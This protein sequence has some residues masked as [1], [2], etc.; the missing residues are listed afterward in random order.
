MQA[1]SQ[2]GAAII[3]AVISRLGYK[4]NV[5]KKPEPLV[6]PAIADR[7]G[8][9]KL[10]RFSLSRPTELQAIGELIWFG[11]EKHARGEM[12]LWEDLPRL[13]NDRGAECIV[14]V[15]TIHFLAL[16]I[17]HEELRKR[18]AIVLDVPKPNA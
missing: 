3:Y 13:R 7:Q 11:E 16:L 6:H 4:R 12:I 15:R 5:P 10:E 1:L 14:L 8:T 2:V 9:L 18:N 17:N